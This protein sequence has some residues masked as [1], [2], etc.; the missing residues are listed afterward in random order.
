M[1]TATKV[2]SG[3]TQTCEPDG[4][5]A[6]SATLL[7]PV[8]RSTCRRC[9]VV[10]F[11]PE[12]ARR[13]LKKLK[14]AWVP[15]TAQELTFAPGRSGKIA[16]SFTNAPVA[17]SIRCSYMRPVSRSPT[18]TRARRESSSSQRAERASKLAVFFVPSSF[19]MKPPLTSNSAC[20]PDALN[21]N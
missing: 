6:M 4:R 20:V 7:F 5:P 3:P 12:P 14:A 1:F 9:R 21:A 10:R 8:E 2:A 19:T 15:L 17:A 11:A 18:L 13:V 16:S